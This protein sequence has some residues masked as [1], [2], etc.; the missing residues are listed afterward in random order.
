[1]N[2][3]ALS[4]VVACAGV[5]S[6]DVLADW[7]ASPNGA[8]LPANNVFAGLTGNDLVRG[9]GIVLSTG[10]TFNSSGWNTTLPD[11]A[12][13]IAQDEYLSFGVNV[14]PGMSLN[15]S[16]LT[17]RYDRSST[18]PNQLVILASYNGFTAA[19][20]PI[21]TDMSVSDAGENNSIPLADSGLTGTV[22]FR[23]YA[24]GATSSAGTFDIE[25]L[26]FAGGDTRGIVLSGS[27]VPAP[28]V[29][30]LAGIGGLL[31]IRRRR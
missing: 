8:S 14:D 1:M 22:E 23:I 11:L 21:W 3:V 4:A 27:V 13:A 24:W 6:A 5:A 18:G 25:S 31:A 2:F 26:D 15:L 28:G 19:S 12:S 20:T 16:D 10:S 17:L 7:Q 9:A 29:L 30:A